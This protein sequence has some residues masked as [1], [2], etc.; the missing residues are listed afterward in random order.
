MASLA[1]V[2][3]ITQLYQRQLEPAA[4][5][6]GSDISKDWHNLASNGGDLVKVNDAFLA[7]A[8]PKLEAAYRRAAILTKGYASSIRSAELKPD[9]YNMP[10]IDPFNR[11]KATSSLSVMGMVEMRQSLARGETLTKALDLST[12]GIDGVGTAFVADG[13]RDFIQ[14][15]AQDDTKLLG[16]ARVTDGDPCSFCAMLASRGPTYTKESFQDSNDRFSDPAF[17]PEVADGSSAAKTHD[18]CCCVLMPVWSN[19]NAIT[20]QSNQLYEDWQRVTKGL[21][22]ASALNAWR[23]FWQA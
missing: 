4:R 6:L 12:T 10:L 19:S 7:I 13:G 16:Y 20:T 11:E 2:E 9:G 8:L 5:A 23:K 17:P 3:A 15:L 21:S 22:G 18:H 14:A 1:D